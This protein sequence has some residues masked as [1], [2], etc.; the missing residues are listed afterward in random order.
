M[1]SSNMIVINYLISNE[2]NK[3]LEKS[4]FYRSLIIQILFAWL[5]ALIQRNLR[6]LSNSFYKL[7]IIC[8]IEIFLI[9]IL[10]LKTLLLIHLKTI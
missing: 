3:L 2:K 5:K 7:L 6:K 8:M 9:E 10:S 1:Q 4:K